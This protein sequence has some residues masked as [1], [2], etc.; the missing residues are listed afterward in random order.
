MPFNF[1][2]MLLEKVKSSMSFTDLPCAATNFRRES[3]D[4]Q[5]LPGPD[6]SRDG[7]SR[8][9]QAVVCDDR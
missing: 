5:V 4:A 1:T 6:G 7:G 3:G 2:I 8:G 9:G